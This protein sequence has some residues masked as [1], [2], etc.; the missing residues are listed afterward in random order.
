LTGDVIGFPLVL[1]VRR[2]YCQLGL[3]ANNPAFRRKAPGL[4]QLC[5]TP[6]AQRPLQ[7][8]NRVGLSLE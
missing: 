7:L 4:N 2:T 8:E 5:H 3:K 6:V 1:I